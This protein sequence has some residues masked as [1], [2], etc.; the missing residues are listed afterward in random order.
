M[1]VYIRVDRFHLRCDYISSYF[2]RVSIDGKEWLQSGT[3]HRKN[4]R[5]GFECVLPVLEGRGFQACI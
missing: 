2:V 1:Q 4:P 5:F 3:K